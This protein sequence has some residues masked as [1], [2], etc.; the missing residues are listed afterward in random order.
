MLLP[1]GCK[2]NFLSSTA[3]S[4]WIKAFKLGISSQVFYQLLLLAYSVNF[5]TFS[6]TATRGLK[7]GIISQMFYPVCNRLRPVQSNY[8]L[9]FFTMWHWLLDWILELRI[10]SWLF[11]PWCYLLRYHCWPEKSTFSKLAFSANVSKGWIQTLKLGI[12]SQL[13]FSLH[14][15]C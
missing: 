14:Y 7:L 6:A 9:Q 1:L 8:V 5:L 15:N 11:Y 4:G 10:I 13:L 2:L 3:S 12:I